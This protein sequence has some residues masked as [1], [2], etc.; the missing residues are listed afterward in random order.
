MSTQLK[1]ALGVVAIIVAGSMVV[2]G[3][4]VAKSYAHAV[5]QEA[6]RSFSVTGEGK[7]VAV[8][9]IA[10]F[11]FSVVTEGNMDVT[12][13][14]QQ[15]TEKMNDAIDYIKSQSIEAK[16]IKTESYSIQPRYSSSYCSPES[17]MTPESSNQ[18]GSTKSASALPRPCPPPSISGYSVSQSALVK[19]RDFKKIGTLLAGIVG[20]GANSV[21]GVAFTIDDQSKVE[22][23]AREEAIQKAKEKAEAMAR[24]GGFKIG[25]LLTISENGQMPPYYYGKGAGMDTAAETPSTPPTI[26]PGSQEINVQATLEYEIK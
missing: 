25:R 5:N 6:S 11:S 13:L 14:Q 12:A 19:V 22:Q 21:S 24:A 26:E 18:E 10:T 8:P 16:D 4:N 7:A 9:D 3:Y 23:Q 17:F 15:N 2:I 1:N 20:H